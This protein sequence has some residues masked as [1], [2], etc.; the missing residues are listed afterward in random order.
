MAII[1]FANVLSRH[2]FHYS[3]SFT[4]EITINAFVW[5][6]VIGSGIAFERG[7]Q[8]GMTFLYARFN[9]ATQRAITI[10][11]ALLGAALYVVVD[12]MLIRTTYTEITLFQ[13]KS[14]A[15]GIPIWCYY[16]LVV[17]VSPWVFVG[18]YRGARGQLADGG[19]NRS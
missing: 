3:F 8:L 16:A 4:E 10:L 5:L 18:I 1:A 13:A 19:G 12:V 11:S 14:P 9:S 6:M 2:L 17:L 15:L 7:S